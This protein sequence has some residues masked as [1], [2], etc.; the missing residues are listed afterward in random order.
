MHVPIKFLYWRK[1]VS[2][3]VTVCFTVTGLNFPIASAQDFHL[4]AP[5]VMVPLSPPLDPPILKGIKVYTDNPFRFDFILD[6]GDAVETPFMAS[7]DRD[8]INRVST[9]PVATSTLQLISLAI[10][11]IYEVVVRAVP[12]VGNYSVVSWLITALKFV[13]DKLNVTK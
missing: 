5:G 4:P 3:L 6:Q 12:S 13:S 2:L 11:G 8:A 10:L 7:H 9:P 1:M